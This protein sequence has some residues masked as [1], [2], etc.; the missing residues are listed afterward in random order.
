MHRNMELAMSPSV[1]CTIYNA[2]VSKESPMWLNLVST[3]LTE[4]NNIVNNGVNC[5]LH[6]NYS[7]NI[8]KQERFGGSAGAD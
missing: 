5:I 6:N 1:Q 4:F 8:C 7:V 3:L 2:N